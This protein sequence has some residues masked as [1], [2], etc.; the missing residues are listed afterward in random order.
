MSLSLSLTGTC[1]GI[2][3][4]LSGHAYSCHVCIPKA[5][6]AWPSALISLKLK[7]GL[8]SQSFL[9]LTASWTWYAALCIVCLCV[10]E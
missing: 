10:H 5:P 7:L 9:T 1:G 3:R 6:F 8:L 2:I 4:T